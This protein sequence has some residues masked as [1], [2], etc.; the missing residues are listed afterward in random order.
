MTKTYYEILEVSHDADPTEI[1]AAFE[2]KKA[3]LEESDDT[4]ISRKQLQAAKETLLDE[5]ARARYD[6]LHG[7]QTDSTA[8]GDTTTN[9]TSQRTQWSIGPQMVSEWRRTLT[10]ANTRGLIGLMCGP[11]AVRL[12]TTVCIAV[13]LTTALN[14]V[15]AVSPS[16]QLSILV[17]SLWMSYGAYEVIYMRQRTAD[18]KEFSQSRFV[19]WP[20]MAI[21]LFG[22]VLLWMGAI[23]GTPDGGARYG[24]IGIT[25]TIISVLL[26]GIGVGIILSILVL[27][28]YFEESPSR[29]SRRIFLGISIIYIAFG[30]TRMGGVFS[31]ETL[32][33]TSSAATSS[34]WVD[35]HIFGPIYIGNLINVCIGSVMII[36]IFGG[37]VAQIWALTVIPWRDRFDHGYHIRPGIWNVAMMT[38]L[39]VA[40]GLF[41][42]QSRVDLGAHIPVVI[43]PTTVVSVM[44]IYP[45]I[46]CGLYLCRR[47]VAERI[48]SASTDQ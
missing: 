16:F 13:V 38:P 35:P 24:T 22:L 29:R 37:A 9:E 11:T 3:A 41:A 25:Y 47:K 12:L 34:P 33:T 45:M 7:I 4:G 44:V 8:A 19:L 6:R 20:L 17:G 18:I 21:H 43:S 27:F 28:G 32:L 14:S 23:A 5:T 36:S 1:K 10:G 30:Y 15:M 46:L 40:G 42:T 31:F 39:V 48:Q 2:R 26:I